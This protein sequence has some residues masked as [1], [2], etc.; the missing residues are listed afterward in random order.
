MYEEFLKIVKNYT[1][2]NPLRILL[3]GNIELRIFYSDDIYFSVLNDCILTFNDLD[4]I[5]LNKILQL[6]KNK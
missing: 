1:S 3:C 6:I 5:Y 2:D 4:E